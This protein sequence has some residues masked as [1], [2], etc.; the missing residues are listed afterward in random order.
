LIGEWD[1]VTRQS[2]DSKSVIDGDKMVYSAA[3]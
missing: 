1:P 2:I 3:N